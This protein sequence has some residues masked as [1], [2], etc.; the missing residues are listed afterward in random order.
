MNLSDSEIDDFV[1]RWERAFGERLERDEA[2]S[3]AARV[4]ALYRK[5][6]R[7]RPD[8]RDVGDMQQGLMPPSA[9]PAQS[10]LEAS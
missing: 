1:A 8:D 7:R 5:L 9:P 4:L 2:R 6:L 10:A 3:I